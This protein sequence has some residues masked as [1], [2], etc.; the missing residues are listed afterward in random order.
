MAETPL[1]YAEVHARTWSAVTE[2]VAKVASGALHPWLASALAARPVFDAL[3]D[4]VGQYVGLSQYHPT[5][6][7]A[8]SYR[9]R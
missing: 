9:N 2:R 1:H 4:S 3:A 5:D 8:A 6:R 7:E